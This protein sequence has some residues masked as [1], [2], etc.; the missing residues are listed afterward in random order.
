MHAGVIRR[1]T[2]G[3]LADHHWRRARAGSGQVAAGPPGIR[4]MVRVCVCVRVRVRLGV[5]RSHLP[6]ARAH[7]HSCNLVT[8]RHSLSYNARTSM[9]C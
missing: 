8:C 3:E 2:P 7:A 5:C 4:Q 6:P 9:T 1:A